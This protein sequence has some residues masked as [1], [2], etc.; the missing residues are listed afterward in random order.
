MKT[1]KKYDYEIILSIVLFILIVYF[2]LSHKGVAI[3]PYFMYIAFG[4]GV[5]SLLSKSF[6]SILTFCWTK[7][8]AALGYI[9]SRLLLSIIFYVVLLPIALLARL[10]RK[11]SLQLKKK[12]GSYFTERNHQYK[13]KDLEN[14]W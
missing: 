10:F 7:F 2:F 9:N 13:S 14:V 4:L 11:D 5:L 1:Q 8:L 3:A 6:A 12:E